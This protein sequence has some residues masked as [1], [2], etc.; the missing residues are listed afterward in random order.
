MSA[1][2]IVIGACSA[3]LTGADDGVTEGDAGQD[4]TGAGDTSIDAGLDGPGP[5]DGGVDAAC[6]KDTT[7]GCPCGVL[8]ASNRCS[9]GGCEPLVFVSSATFTGRIAA[10]AVEAMKVADATCASLA[11]KIPREPK[12]TF[13]PWLSGQNGLARFTRS[14]RPYRL[15]DQGRSVIAT[16]FA[17]LTNELGHPIDADETGAQLL[18]AVGVWTGAGRDGNPKTDNCVNWTISEP[19]TMGTFGLTDRT[20]PSWSEHSSAGCDQTYH[21]YCFEQLP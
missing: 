7:S 17:A 5:G 10:D 19:S 20:T 8:C 13:L 2:A 21:L 16:S 1:L 6:D 3:T 15:S 18:G 11:I 9:K 4:A 12:T 14:S